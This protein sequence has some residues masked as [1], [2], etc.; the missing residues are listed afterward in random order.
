M[1]YFIKTIHVWNSLKVYYLIFNISYIYEEINNII[2][3]FIIVLSIKDVMSCYTHLYSL[4]QWLMNILP[5]TSNIYWKALS[6]K[7]T[8][9]DFIY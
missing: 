7:Y 4:Q 2:K 9:S 1:F 8:D 6:S 3:Q 5:P